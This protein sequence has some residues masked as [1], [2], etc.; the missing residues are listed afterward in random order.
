VRKSSRFLQ[1]F[2]ITTHCI[3]SYWYCVFMDQN[4]GI[5]KT[6]FLNIKS[7]QILSAVAQILS[8][9]MLWHYTFEPRNLV[10]NLQQLSLIHYDSDVPDETFYSQDLNELL[11][12]PIAETVR[13]PVQDRN[14]R[15]LAASFS[16]QNVGRTKPYPRPGLSDLYWSGRSYVVLWFVIVIGKLDIHQ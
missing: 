5:L 3:G 12:M 14:Q 8:F 13:N 9:F 4:H 2:F 10:F 7:S 6:G 1:W 15:F 11:C 16:R